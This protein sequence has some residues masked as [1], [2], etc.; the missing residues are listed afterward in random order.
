MPG[1]R[2][3]KTFV[4]QQC[5]FSADATGIA[6]HSS[7]SA[8]DSVARDDDA[9]WIS[10]NSTTDSLGRHGCKPFRGAVLLGKFMVCNAVAIG[11]LQ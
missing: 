7:M 4:G 11:N 2:L 10:A 5:C 6:G 3:K 1:I 8:N 9:D